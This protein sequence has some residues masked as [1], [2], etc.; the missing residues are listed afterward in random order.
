VKLPLAL[1]VSADSQAALKPGGPAESVTIKV[2]NPGAKAVDLNLDDI[3]LESGPARDQARPTVVHA[4]APANAYHLKA[5]S[6]LG[7][8][9]VFS[10][11]LLPSMQTRPFK[12]LTV[13][14]WTL[15]VDA[16]TAG[17]LG[18][19]RGPPA[20]SSGTSGY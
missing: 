9:S 11:D 17:S 4:R 3:G 12:A 6:V 14:R 15:P 2:S 1:T 5:A 7:H 20:S 18:S 13:H 10:P 16:V 19:D 8:L